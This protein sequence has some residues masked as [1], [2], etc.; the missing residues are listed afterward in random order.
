MW[1]DDT[2]N[3]NSVIQ[4]SCALIAQ[5]AAF[6]SQEGAVQE[7]AAGPHDGKNAA[8]FLIFTVGLGQII[9]AVPI[10]CSTDHFGNLVTS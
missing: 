8:L 1:D 3:D 2:V 5:A 4:H 10:E 6:T 7:D 9:F